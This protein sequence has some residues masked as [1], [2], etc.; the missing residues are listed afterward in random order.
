MSMSQHSTQH[1]SFTSL[2]AFQRHDDE[3]WPYKE[4]YII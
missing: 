4:A 3:D 1:T 2:I